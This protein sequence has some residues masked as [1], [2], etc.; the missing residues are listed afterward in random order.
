MGLE[1]LLLESLDVLGFTGGGGETE[2]E[3][4]ALVCLIISLKCYLILA[5]DLEN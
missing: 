1:G 3:S 5:V 2:R 4:K